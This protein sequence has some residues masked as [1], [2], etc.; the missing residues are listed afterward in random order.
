LTNDPAENAIPVWHPSGQRLVFSDGRNG[1]LDIFSAGIQDRVASELLIGPRRDMPVSFSPDARFLLYG[2]DQPL[3]HW[4]GMVLDTKSNETWPIFNRVFPM[5]N[6][7]FSPSGEFV[8]FESDESGQSEVYAYRFSDPDG[9]RW[10]ISRDGGV[11]PLWSRDG[12]EIFYISL[13]SQL[14]SAEVSDYAEFLVGPVTHVFDASRYVGR[15]VGTGAVPFD[16]SLD[17]TRFLMTRRPNPEEAIDWN[18][19]LVVVLNALESIND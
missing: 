13:D 5:L 9:P 14:M 3:G 18:A 12:T 7:M 15:Q 16:Q 11:K 1:T 8:V 6:P 2:E 4:T 10:K 19:R 17:G